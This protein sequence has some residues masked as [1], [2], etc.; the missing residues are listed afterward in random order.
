MGFASGPTTLLDAMDLHTGTSNLQASSLVQSILI[1]LVESWGYDGFDAHIRSVSAFYRAKRDVF[2][3][4]MKENMEGLAEWTPPEAGMFFWFKLLLKPSSS[5][6]TQGGAAAAEEDEGDSSDLV[7]TKAY[8]NGVLAL[9]GTVF[10]PNGRKTAFV[11]ASFSLLEESDVREALK[12]L[13]EVV[14]Q[15]RGEA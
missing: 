2:Q 8:E 14:K 7:R 11:R 1:A 12:R 10:L 13:K 5:A 4:A 6:N 9:P 3:A 15:E